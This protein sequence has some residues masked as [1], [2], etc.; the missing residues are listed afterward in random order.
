MS[1]G[2]LG[3]RWQF[4]HRGA[5]FSTAFGRLSSGADDDDTSPIFCCTR[6]YISL[7]IVG[8]LSRLEEKVPLAIPVFIED[9]DFW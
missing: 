9:F 4:F 6:S 3:K 1:G 7:T 8:T 2:D 5:D